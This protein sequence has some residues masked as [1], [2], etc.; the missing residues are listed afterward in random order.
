MNN[1]WGEK[2]RHA[3]PGGYQEGRTGRGG[4][5]ENRECRKPDWMTAVYT[6]VRDSVENTE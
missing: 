6:R 5:L 3:S 1:T 4:I 2:K